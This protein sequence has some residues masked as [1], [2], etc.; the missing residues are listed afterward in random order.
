M[1]PP[2]TR[3]TLFGWKKLR[4]EQESIRQQRW[5]RLR[6]LLASS[7]PFT[8]LPE[9]PPAHLLALHLAADG[10]VVFVAGPDS[11]KKKDY[12]KA[13]RLAIFGMFCYSESKPVQH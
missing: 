5:D 1:P 6:S 12:D 8:D 4:R 3:Q 2:P 11:P 9:R 10:K 13:I 7:A